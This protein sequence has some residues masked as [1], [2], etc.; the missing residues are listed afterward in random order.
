MDEIEGVVLEE[1][2]DSE[3]WEF[4]SETTKKRVT[5]ALETAVRH[6]VGKPTGVVE[7]LETEYQSGTCDWCGYQNSGITIMVD[8]EKVFEYSRGGGLYDWEED[9]V[10]PFVALQNWLDEVAEFPPNPYRVDNSK[11]QEGV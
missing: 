6:R 8:G 5:G 2:I 11:S 4:H 3:E 1:E 10:S 9:T 7:S